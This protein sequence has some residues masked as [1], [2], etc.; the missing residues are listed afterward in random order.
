MRETLTKRCQ[1]AWLQVLETKAPLVFPFPDARAAERAK[2]AFYDALRGS[3]DPRL[4]EA[5]AAIEVSLDRK[6][7][8]VTL[9]PRSENPFYKALGEALDAALP[10]DPLPDTPADLD[11]KMAESLARFESLR[12]ESSADSPAPRPGN[13]YFNREDE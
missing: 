12:G 5:K 9:R 2:F 6:A 3:D 8:T 1:L 4:A 13:K 10:A 7:F 11:A